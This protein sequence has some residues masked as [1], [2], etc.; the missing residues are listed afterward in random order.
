MRGGKM[1][2]VPYVV[3]R[4]VGPFFAGVCMAGAGS[5]DEPVLAVMLFAAALACG[6]ISLPG[7]Y[8]RIERLLDRSV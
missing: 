4:L 7:T 8:R 3:N 5:T 2:S 6:W 1:V